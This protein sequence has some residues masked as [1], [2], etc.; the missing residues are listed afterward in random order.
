MGVIPYYNLGQATGNLKINFETN[1]IS[2]KDIKNY[3]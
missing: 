2:F 1:E 3:R